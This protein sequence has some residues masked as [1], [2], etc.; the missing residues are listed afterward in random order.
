MGEC[1]ARVVQ[2]GREYER[3]GYAV[4]RWGS[5]SLSYMKGETDSYLT[6]LPDAVDPREPRAL[7]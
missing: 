6:C 5:K 4:A 7:R 2:L 3:D 1:S